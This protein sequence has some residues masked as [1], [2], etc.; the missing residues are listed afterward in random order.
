MLERIGCAVTVAGDGLK[1][2]AALEVGSFDLILMDCQMP[3]LDGYQATRR[4]REREQRE[5]S[6]RRIPIVALTGHAMEENRAQCLAAGM[7]DH[8]SKPMTRA[9]LKEVLERW[10]PE[11]CAAE[12]AGVAGVAGV[13][14]AAGTAGTAGAGAGAAGA[15]AADAGAADAGAA[16]AGAADAG[17]A[18]AGAA[19]S[20]QQP[21]ERPQVLDQKV[22][23]AIRALQRDGAVNLLDKVIGHYLAET[24]A[25]VTEIGRSIEAGDADALTSAAHAF[26]SS[27]ANVGALVLSSL[28]LKLE[29]MGRSGELERA[30]EML[31]TLDAENAAVC[32]ALAQNLSRSAH[33]S[34]AGF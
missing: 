27:S 3:E 10:L 20:E 1:A 26:K 22:L 33:D 9:Q 11:E 32:S 7:D 34:C 8:L 31:L 23:D 12:A 29:K 17:A 4:I 5:G 18:D 6:G 25:L 21:A 19:G 24:P 13:A 30:R 15:G 14:E 28:C 16:D 2:L